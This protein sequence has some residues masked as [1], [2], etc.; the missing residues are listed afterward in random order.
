MHSTREIQR[1]RLARSEGSCNAAVLLCLESETI[2]NWSPK[3][4][5]Y[6]LGIDIMLTMRQCTKMADRNLV[7][8]RRILNHHFCCSKS[9]N[10]ILAIW[11][12]SF[13]SETLE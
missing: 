10:A 12:V 13:G 8:R 9:K 2:W 11:S 3:I 7:R 4:C 5:G 6:S 1:K